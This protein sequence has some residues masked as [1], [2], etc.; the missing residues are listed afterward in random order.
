[1]KELS[2]TPKN[3]RSNSTLHEDAERLA[4][5][6][7]L[8]HQ[9]NNSANSTVSK[10]KVPP[11]E[12]L[13][14]HASDTVVKPIT[15]NK[16]IEKPQE[17]VFNKESLPFPAM[18]LEEVVAGIETPQVESHLG[19]IYGFLGTDICVYYIDLICSF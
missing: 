15:G 19:D 10:A 14:N 11:V 3:G 2:V 5:A 12:Q 17:I 16:E 1:M 7:L 18:T 8:Q 4:T 9:R 13:I 6:N